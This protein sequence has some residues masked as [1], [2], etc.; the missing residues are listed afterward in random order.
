MGT[1]INASSFGSSGAVGTSWRLLAAGGLA[2][3][4]DGETAPTNTLVV[5]YVLIKYN[6]LQYYIEFP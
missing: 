5:S 6:T 2:V 3:V 1:H 4:W